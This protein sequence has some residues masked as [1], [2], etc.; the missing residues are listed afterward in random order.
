MDESFII[1]EDK[2]IKLRI[3]KQLRFKHGTSYFFSGVLKRGQKDAR[4]TLAIGLDPPFGGRKAAKKVILGALP[5]Q[6]WMGVEMRTIRKG[7]CSFGDG[8]IEV[9]GKYTNPI[10]VLYRWTVL[11]RLNKHHV[12]I[13]LGGGGNLDSFEKMG[14]DIIKSIVVK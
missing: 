13:D 1:F 11:Y 14:T 2:N 8:G 9:L 6:E 5:N 12:Y 7:R 3:P 10:T 4:V